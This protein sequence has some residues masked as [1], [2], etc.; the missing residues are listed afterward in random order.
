MAQLKQELVRSFEGFSASTVEHE[1]VRLAKACI[2]A[3]GYPF[4]LL[5][6]NSILE[7]N[8]VRI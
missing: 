8:E 7:R 6:F 1:H 4:E 2:S 3:G 5:D